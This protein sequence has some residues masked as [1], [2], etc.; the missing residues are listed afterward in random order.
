MLYFSESE[1][2]LNS[3][4]TGTKVFWEKIKKVFGT[5]EE[6]GINLDF[7]RNW[8]YSNGS[9]KFLL[10]LSNSRYSS[11][12]WNIRLSKKLENFHL[13]N[14]LNLE[15][16]GKKYG[17]EAAILCVCENDGEWRGE[18]NEEVSE[19][20]DWMNGADEWAMIWAANEL[21]KWN[22][23]IPICDWSSQFLEVETG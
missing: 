15:V 20:N 23:R 5:F 8:Y 19:A 1:T 12:L 13:M 14:L 9:H 16:G 21:K 7:V 18:R 10:H 2:N 6:T 22:H 4:G 17:C 3:L 11:K